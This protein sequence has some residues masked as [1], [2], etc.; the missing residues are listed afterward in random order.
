MAVYIDIEAIKQK[1]LEEY[2]N[3][4]Y[5]EDLAEAVRDCSDA[6]EACERLR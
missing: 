5:R 3:G 2:P 1:L 6:C 4:Y